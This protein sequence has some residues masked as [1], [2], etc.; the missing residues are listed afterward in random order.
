[1][2]EEGDFETI[3]VDRSLIETPSIGN[4]EFSES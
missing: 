2:V 4:E 3:H 1:M